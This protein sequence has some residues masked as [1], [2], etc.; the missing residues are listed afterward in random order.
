VHRTEIGEFWRR[1]VYVPAAHARNE[2]GRNGS[3]RG[4]RL[5]GRPRVRHPHPEPIPR[6][7]DLQR[8]AGNVVVAAVEAA[9][10]HKSAALPVQRAPRPGHDSLDVLT[11]LFTTGPWLPPAATPC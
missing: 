1:V 10:V 11:Q 5:E 3:Q 8:T 4:V 2:A 6:I 7:S 9:R